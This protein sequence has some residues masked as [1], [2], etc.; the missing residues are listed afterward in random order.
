[1]SFQDVHCAGLARFR[2]DKVHRAKHRPETDPRL[3]FNIISS[4]IV[5]QAPSPNACIMYHLLKNKWHPVPK[6]EEALMEMFE[7]RPEKG[8][9]VRFR[10]IM[11]NRNW[12]FFEEVR[13]SALL[14]AYLI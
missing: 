13:C 2:S 3:M 8:E 9:H 11:P 14:E 7:R 1:M 12:T 10:K 4:A 5:N 6:T